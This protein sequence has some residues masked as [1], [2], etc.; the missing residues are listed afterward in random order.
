M[1]VPD[2]GNVPIHPL[3]RAPH[4]DI[5]QITD[6]VINGVSGVG[7]SIQGA[8]DVPFDATLK[9]TGPARLVDGAL[10]SVRDVVKSL[11]RKITR[12]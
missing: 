12:W 6:T 7:E 4:E 8:L 3:K 10:D 1:R 2:L 5:G 9:L 11:N